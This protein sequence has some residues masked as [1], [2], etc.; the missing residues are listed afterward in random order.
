VAAGRLGLGCARTSDGRHDAFRLEG[1]LVALL[2]YMSCQGAIR[3]VAGS[4]GA[5]D[6]V[7][8][9]V[10]VELEAEAVAVQ[11]EAPALL[12]VAAHLLL[13]RR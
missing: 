5:V 13:G 4:V 10:A 1:V 3:L 7:A 6:A 2:A 12:A 11:L 8:R 9:H